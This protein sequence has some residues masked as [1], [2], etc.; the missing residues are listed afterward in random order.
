MEWKSTVDK[1]KTLPLKDKICL[2]QGMQ[3]HMLITILVVEGH[4][5][6]V[7]KDIPQKIAQ[8]I[9]LKGKVA[10]PQI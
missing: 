7:G 3:Q 4:L 1:I 9:K 6:V 2:R 5:E 8:M 10:D